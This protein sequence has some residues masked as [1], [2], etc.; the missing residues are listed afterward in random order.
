MSVHS[1]LPTPVGP[2]KCMNSGFVPCSGIN[3]VST[4]CRAASAQHDTYVT[5]S[6]L[7]DWVG[8]HNVERVRKRHH[9]LLHPHVEHRLIILSEH[10]GECLADGTRRQLLAGKLLL[11]NGLE[12]GGAIAE[13]RTLR[14]H[15]RQQLPGR[16]KRLIQ[17]VCLCTQQQQQQPGAFHEPPRHRSMV[18]KVFKFRLH[19]YSTNLVKLKMGYVRILVVVLLVL[20]GVVRFPPVQ[21]D[22]GFPHTTRVSHSP[23]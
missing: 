10:F 18:G 16:T 2:E 14:L 15:R 9:H 4:R 23:F 11:D 21:L 1:D 20:L 3:Y 22:Y 19:K 12:V 7:G 6:L 13:E 8:E 5:D 17:C